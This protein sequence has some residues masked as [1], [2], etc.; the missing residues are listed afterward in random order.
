MRKAKKILWAIFFLLPF[1]ILSSGN[2]LAN[3]IDDEDEAPEIT[4]RVARISYLRGDAKIKHA[5]ERD[6]ERVTQNLPIVE[7][8]EISTDAGA[9]LEIQFNRHNYLRLSEN[10]YLKITTLRYEGIA[11]SLPEG[12]M[13]LRV[14]TFDKDRDSFEIDAPRT[15]VAIQQAG[16]YRIDAGGKNDSQI[17]ISV[18]EGGQARVYSENAGFSLRSGRSA[19]IQITGNFAGEYETSDASKYADE[20]DT[21]ALQ[22]DTVIAKRLQNAGYD[23][24]YDNDV[25]GAE[26]LSEYGEWIHTR[27]YGY[28]WKPYSTATSSYANWSPYRYG[29]WRWIPPYG[30]TWVNDEPWGYATYHHGR[31]VYLDNHWAWT[32]YGQT[33]ARRNWWRPA[34]VVVTYSG[35]LICWYPL[36]YNYGYYN[37]NSVYIDRRRYNR[38]IINNT[39]VVVNPTPTNNKRQRSLNGVPIELAVPPTGVV[40]VETNDFGKG[41]RNIRPAPIEVAKKALSK[42]PFENEN[43]PLPDYRNVKSKM[44]RE[45]VAEIPRNEQI[46]V[47]VKTG[48]TERK[49][50][51]PVDENLRKERIYGNRQPREK[52][53]P[54]IETGENPGKIGTRD[55]GAVKRAPRQIINQ[56]EVVETRK[57]APRE[58]PSDSFPTRNRSGK[59]N[60][61][62]DDTPASKPRNRVKEM[63]APAYE[64]PQ[65]QER[66]ER[67]EQRRQIPPQETP[68]SESPP[69]REEPREAKPPQREQPSPKE[70]RK[71]SP[72]TK[73]KSEKVKPD[74]N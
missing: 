72:P 39:T 70:E 66:Q 43:P 62:N 59:T 65:Q 61:E 53:P 48:A 14:L 63:P 9:R 52:T 50:G 4:A 67:K 38:T 22:R 36:P 51:V 37:Y 30:W 8:D 2:A 34:L 18:T 6:W 45:I 55:T 25:S 16:M 33:R 17:R 58:I 47:R 46:A 27:K 1:L 69:K 28:V 15:T 26:D 54:I 10:A 21:W 31:W 32:P 74:N 68:R 29:N 40:A 11:V 41:T 35:S 44:N 24:Y 57:S 19:D 13:S 64:P 60:I 23:K 3:P 56:E 12:I 20:F 73:D 42:T 5:G 49:I 71:V 7:G